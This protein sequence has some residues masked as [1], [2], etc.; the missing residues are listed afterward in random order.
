MACAITGGYTID[1][2]ESVGGIQTIWVLEKSNITSYTETSGTLSTITLASSGMTFYKIEV[3]RA[4]AFS[5][6][7]ITASQ[8]N[9]T[10]YYT[11]EINFPIN[12]RSATVR[13]LI[14]VL[15]KNKCVFITL[16]G[17]G[18]YR[19]YGL[20]F[21][22]FLDSAESGSGTSLADRN[23][24]MCKFSSMET[25][26]FIYCPPASLTGKLAS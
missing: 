8:E 1:C 12:S 14:N 23:G 3:P 16:E 10:F 22:L 7:T 5:S 9:G 26:D 21:G 4:T 17:D 25:E 18:L 2:R 11:H 15:A 13:N 24:Y 19:A 6:N 20:K